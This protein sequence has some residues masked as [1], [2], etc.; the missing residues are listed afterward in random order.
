[1]NSTKIDACIMVRFFKKTDNLLTPQKVEAIKASEPP[2][3]AKK[4][5]SFLC[6]FQYNARFMDNYAQQTDVLRRLLKAQVFS[7]AK[8]HRV[9]FERLK[10]ALS[11]DTVLAYFD[12]GAKHEVRVDGCP[13]GILATLVQC[14]PSDD[15]W[16]GVQYAR[17]TLTDT[18]RNYSQIELEML[19]A[20]FG[21]RKFH[22]FLYGLRFKI[23]VMDHKP[24][25]T[26]LG[27][28]RLYTATTN[29][30]TNA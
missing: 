4:M 30:G 7:W 9:A 29:D 17:R 24:L 20:D 21:C 28:R 11:S 15:K 1:M 16:R 26:T 6:T 2:H 23:I 13:L 27:I 18:E 3:N 5:D 12:P 8:E 25:G 14:A 22:V 19:T 10:E